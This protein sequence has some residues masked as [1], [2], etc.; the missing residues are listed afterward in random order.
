MIKIINRL[1][2][3]L[4][5]SQVFFACSEEDK[6]TF[7]DPDAPA[8]V[9]LNTSSISIKNLH[10]KSIVKYQRPNDDN[11]LYVKAVYES[12]P[13]VIREAKAS[14]YVDTLVL[15]GFNAAS[16]YKVKIYSVGK[17]EKESAPVEIS[18][19]PLTPPVVDAFPSLNISAIFGGV[20]CQYQNEHQGELKL[21]LLADTAGDNRYT[22]LRSFVSNNPA[23]RFT[24]TGLESEETNFAAYLQDRYGNRSDTAWFSSLT[25]L[26]EEEIDKSNLEFYKDLPSDLLK[27][28]EMGA[29][30][31]YAPWKMWDNDLAPSWSGVYVM[32]LSG[33]T[34]PYTLTIKLAKE[35]TLSRIIMHHWRLNGGGFKGGAPKYFQVYGSSKDKPADDLF[36]DDWTLLGDFHSEIPSGKPEPTQADI[37]FAVFDGE[38]FFFEATDEIPDPFVSIKFIR[39]RFMGNW[40]GRQIGDQANTT[41]AEI[42]LFGQ[43]KNN[44]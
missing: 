42:R 29:H 18:V 14:L 30:S 39:L 11:L 22:L 1:L 21:T 2:L 20:R 4:V 3:I 27:W 26:F 33:Y 32:N 5:M 15:E 40:E 35:I 17:N 34:Y 8:P 43:Y 23:A 28:T 25:P 44:N 12:A 6:I 38:P 36:G 16:D 9:A 10:G 31:N 37:N 24:Y 7:Y 19:S 13:N 41:V